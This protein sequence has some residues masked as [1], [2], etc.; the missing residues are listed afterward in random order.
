MAK[1]DQR[2]ARL[3]RGMS[4]TYNKRVFRNMVWEPVSEA[5]EEHLIESAVDKVTVSG[6]GEGSQGRAETRQKFEFRVGNP[7]AVEDEPPAP[8]TRTRAQAGA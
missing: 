4:Y 7:D 1:S 6:G 8:R 5:E 3:V 2:Y